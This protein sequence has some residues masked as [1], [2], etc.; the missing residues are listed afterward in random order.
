M[1]YAAQFNKYTIFIQYENEHEDNITLH[2]IYKLC[3]AQYMYNNHK[4]K[5]LGEYG[6]RRSLYRCIIVI[7]WRHLLLQIP[8]HYEHRTGRCIFVT[9][10]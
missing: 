1:V 10:N 5:K 8:G 6:V 3:T 9:V 4:Y 2:I 7:R